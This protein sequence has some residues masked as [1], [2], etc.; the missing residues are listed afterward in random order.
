M[1]RFMAAPFGEFFG[2]TPA[3]PPQPAPKKT[4]G[5]GVGGLCCSAPDGS[6]GWCFDANYNAS[7]RCGAAWAYDPAGG[8]AICVPDTS[9]DSWSVG[10]VHP[11]CPSGAAPPPAPPPPS[12]PPPTP[13][14]TPTPTPPPTPPPAPPPS[15]GPRPGPPVS[16]CCRPDGTFF[17][18]K[19]LAECPPGTVEAD[20]VS[21]E[22]PV[23]P[24]DEA[25]LAC[26]ENGTYNLYDADTGEHIASDVAQAD[27]PPGVQIVSG[28]DPRCGPPTLPTAP[29]P[30]PTDGVPSPGPLPT[31]PPPG[32]TDGVPPSGPLPSLPPP[33]LPSA[34]PGAPQLPT[35]S[36]FTSRF[37]PC[38]AQPPIN[39][40]QLR[41]D[42]LPSRPDSWQDQW[43]QLT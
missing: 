10:W 22:C 42:T 7:G 4:M 43:A 3:P 21:G 35:Q 37:V 39:V 32:P 36:P 19:D 28:D 5:Q 15:N 8:G 30:G 6:A 23:A 16:K 14:P 31:A 13:T 25:A 38:G 18:A 12:P 11:S 40:R 9:G 41:T 2:N 17:G 33:S 29:P 20:P 24:S 1:N 26:Q 34:P 27:L